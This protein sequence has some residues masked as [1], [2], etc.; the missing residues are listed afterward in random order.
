MSYFVMYDMTGNKSRRPQRVIQSKEIVLQKQTLEMESGQLFSEAKGGAVPSFLPSEGIE[1]RLEAVP[2]AREFVRN[3]LGFFEGFIRTSEFELNTFKLLKSS[4][5]P[6]KIDISCREPSEDLKLRERSRWCMRSSLFPSLPV[7]KDREPVSVVH[8]LMQCT[9]SDM[10]R[11]E[12]FFSSCHFQTLSP[13]N[14]SI[15]HVSEQDKFLSFSQSETVKP[16]SSAAEKRKC[17]MPR[18]PSMRMQQRY[19]ATERELYDSRFGDMISSDSLIPSPT[20]TCS[21]E[22]NEVG[23]DKGEPGDCYLNTDFFSEST[24]HTYGFSFSS[25]FPKRTE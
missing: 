19:E 17:H 15:Q 21:S 13:P 14:H 9:I 23:Q 12:S 16:K 1:R 7:V 25:D 2:Q 10:E 3:L 22:T 6:C 5:A 24:L 20:Y 18:N 11:L 8:K 4:I